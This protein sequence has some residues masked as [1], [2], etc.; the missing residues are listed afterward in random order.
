MRFD[1]PSSLNWAVSFTHKYFLPS[2]KKVERTFGISL[3][4]NEN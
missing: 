1:M 4:R 3:D 2:M